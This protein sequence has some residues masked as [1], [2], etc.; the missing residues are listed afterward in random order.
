[1]KVLIWKCQG[2]QE[3]SRDSLNPFKYQVTE[4]IIGDFDSDTILLTDDE[5]LINTAKKNYD[6]F[7]IPTC[8]VEAQK[9]Q[10]YYTDEQKADLDVKTSVNKIGEIVNL[11][12]QLN[13]LMWQNINNGQSIEDNKELYDDI[14][15]L[16]VLSNIEIDRAK[17]EYAVDSGT[18]LRYIK[19][20]YKIT[21]N[22]K[23]VKPMF[24]KMI[25]LENGYKLS[26]K[27]LYKYFDT[28]MDYLQKC[29]SGF[30]FRQGREQ[31]LEVLPFSSLVKEKYTTNASIT[32]FELRDRIINI[33]K[34]TNKELQKLYIDY[35][36]K[37]KDEKE[38]IKKQAADIKQE[39]TE[40]INELSIN[41]TTMY[42]LLTALDKK[43][44]RHIQK[45]I[46]ET[47]FGTPNKTFFKMIID[48]RGNIGKVVE[49][50]T[51]NI[52]LY[53]FTYEKEKII[54]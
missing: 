23:T 5:L 39:C 40:Y 17:K 38:D 45:R 27:H 34:D 21:E 28:P 52:K 11:S 51:G 13:S 16:A 35:D 18:E 9:I 47:L 36:N 31:K 4:G 20:K 42:L 50:E 30:Q 22:G 26:E 19:E 15:K 49:N 3:S 1:M 8:F 2:T 43:E 14:C 29:I 10:R 37:N 32:Y 7:K 41:E 44:Y 33:V 53:N 48:N 6:K 46:F 12:Q 54:T 25:T 24:F